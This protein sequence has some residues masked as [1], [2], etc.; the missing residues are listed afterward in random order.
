MG[1][2]A[3]PAAASEADGRIGGRRSA[4]EPSLK[5][6]ALRLLSQR[7]HT[8]RELERKLGRYVSAEG[9]ESVDGARDMQKAQVAQAGPAPFSPAQLAQV[10]D[11]LTALGFLDE[12]RAAESLINRRANGL[13]AVRLRREMQSK[14]LAREL[15]DETLG[16][17]LSGETSNELHRAR[18]IW[19]RKFATVALPGDPQER[20]KQRARQMRF[21]LARG[22]S[23]EVVRRVVGGS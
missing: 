23:G 19:Q 6:R 16:E 4:F 17:L 20:A 10:L 2:P 8:R 11:E 7:E 22:F 3:K 15:I 9:E 1:L 21:L 18:E 14:G 13:G 5:G 12:R